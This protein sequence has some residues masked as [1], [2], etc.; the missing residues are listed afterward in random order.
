MP[1]RE[2]VAQVLYSAFPEAR[3]AG[4]DW[5]DWITD[6]F[7]RGTWV[8]P[9]LGDSALCHADAWPRADR[10]TFASSDIAPAHIGWFEGAVLSG[11]AAI[12]SLLEPHP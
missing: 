5:H 10:L 8:A 4:Y 2:T 1:T 12:R 9:A 11:Q 6:P 3:F 7:A